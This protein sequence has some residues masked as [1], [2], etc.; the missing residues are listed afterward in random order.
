M[1]VGE[2]AQP[3]LWITISI[4]TS[5]FWPVYAQR[6]V[7]RGQVLWVLPLMV[8][9]FPS[10][11][12]AKPPGQS[13]E[14]CER[15]LMRFL[16]ALSWVERR[17]FLS[18]SVTRSSRPVPRLRAD[19]K[20]SS[21][22]EEF[23]LVY[24]PEPADDG[25]MHALA[26]MREGRGL[27]HPGYAFLSY[28][29]VLERAFSDKPKQRVPWMT[30]QLT[31]LKDREAL[32]AIA[33]ITAAGIT[34][35]GAHLYN[36][37]RSAVAHANGDAIIDP[38]DPSQLRAVESDL[39]IIA[40]LAE[41]AI[42][43]VLGVET[44]NTVYDKHLY[45]LAGFKLILGERLVDA[46]INEI[47][48]GEETTVDFPPMD[49]RIRRRK[50]HHTLA[51]MSVSRLERV[52]KILRLVLRS[53]NVVAELRFDLDFASERLVFDP[54]DGLFGQ[55]DESPEAADAVAD[56]KSFGNELL[57]NG[58]IQILNSETQEIIARKD[59][60]YLR[61][62]FVDVAVADDEVRLWREKAAE[63]RDPSLIMRHAMDRLARRYTTTVR[64]ANL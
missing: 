43:E 36:A 2:L 58:E 38:D 30:H 52:G 4:E 40:A 14:A 29:R 8:G 33:K 60:Y 12:M 34:D 56:L 15:V 45:E 7:F 19:P 62:A 22:C 28:F 9:F 5:S 51:N 23:R 26:L 32:S 35:I 55:D 53:E 25:A 64:S 47:D 39:P 54:F 24:L 49:V 20:S 21:V 16:S 6:V 1:I 37:R 10:I 41:R 57:M 18:T 61:N 44:S 11:A 27:N 3:G 59:A 42:E 17:G 63:R 46:I 48:V 13:E 50:Q 31:T